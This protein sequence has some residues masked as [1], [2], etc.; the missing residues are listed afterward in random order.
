LQDS[1]STEKAV[2][3]SVIPATAGSINR[4][5]AVQTSWDKKHDPISKITR[6]KKGA[7]GMAQAVEH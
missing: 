3:V 6:A 2:Y 7:G 4:R 5:I 1:I